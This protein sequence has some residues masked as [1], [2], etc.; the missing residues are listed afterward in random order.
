MSLRDVLPNSTFSQNRPDETFGLSGGKFE[1]NCL[2]SSICLSFTGSFFIS[3]RSFSIDVIPD[4]RQESMSSWDIWKASAGIWWFFVRFST[5]ELL[6]LP[7]LLFDLFEPNSLK[8]LKV[9]FD[10]AYDGSAG[11]ILSEGFFSSWAI[12][13]IGELTPMRGP[14]LRLAGERSLDPDNF[15]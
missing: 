3:A 5:N 14:D 1:E 4:I 9:F 6:A 10:D 13:I 7:L 12:G 8:K 15:F 11:Y 2:T